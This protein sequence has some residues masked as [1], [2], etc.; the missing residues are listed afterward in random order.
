MWP[1]ECSVLAYVAPGLPIE[2]ISKGKGLP[3]PMLGGVREAGT[4]AD[5]GL[6]ARFLGGLFGG[7][8]R[9]ESASLS[10]FEGV[11]RVDVVTLCFSA[12]RCLR[13]SRTGGS[14]VS[15]SSSSSSSPELGGGVGGAVFSAPETTGIA[16]GSG[17]GLATCARV[18]V[19]D[20]NMSE[21]MCKNVGI[22][23]LDVRECRRFI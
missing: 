23:P 6:R 21:A 19:S 7:L 8:R 9:G 18:G 2:H 5:E 14:V 13:L 3:G 20:I 10:V 11:G 12:R 17:V 15:S 1:A 22:S 16:A 4:E